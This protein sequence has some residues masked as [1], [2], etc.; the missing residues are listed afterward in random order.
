MKRFTTFALLYILFLGTSLFA[1]P[2]KILNSSE[3]KLALEKLNT[4]GSVLYVAAHP[5]DDN[6]SMF[7]AILA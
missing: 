5:D 3:L 2:A 6:T 1:Q 7:I 4:L